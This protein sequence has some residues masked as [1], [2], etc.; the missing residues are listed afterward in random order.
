MSGLHAVAGLRDSSI[1]VLPYSLK[2]QWL[3][4][5]VWNA[6]LTVKCSDAPVTVLDFRHR[7]LYAGT[8]LGKIHAFRPVSGAEDMGTLQKVANE[9]ERLGYGR[10]A[11]EFAKTGK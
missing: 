2:S 6:K 11:E 7:L 4:G 10:S 8:A 5:A 1:C 3:Q 9:M